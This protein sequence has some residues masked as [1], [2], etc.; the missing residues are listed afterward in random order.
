MAMIGSRYGDLVINTWGFPTRRSFSE[1]HLRCFFEK[2]LE[3][4]DRRKLT[5]LWP[6]DSAQQFLP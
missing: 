1:S 4:E 3:L 5:P 6:I 2:N